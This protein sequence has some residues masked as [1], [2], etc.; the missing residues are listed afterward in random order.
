[1]ALPEL[2]DEQEAEYAARTVRPPEAE[3]PYKSRTLP[4]FGDELF[5]Y[6]EIDEK[7]KVV[8]EIF[9][10]GNP[11]R[12]EPHMV[13]P[14]GLVLDIGANIGAFTLWMRGQFREADI[15]CFEPE[16]ENY[17]LLTL[18]TSN[19]EGIYCIPEGVMG[20]ESRFDLRVDGSGSTIALG[21][22]FKP[23]LKRSTVTV[24]CVSFRDVINRYSR[25]NGHDH[26]DLLKIDAEGAEYSMFAA[27][28]NEF[29][30]IQ[31]LPVDLMNK[32][33]Y[34]TMEFHAP[35]QCPFT[36]EQTWRGFGDLVATLTRTHHVTILGSVERGGY[37]Y[38]QRYG[39]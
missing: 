11:Y 3:P 27:P 38:A 4:N 28:Q 1:M 23:E 8:E 6:R 29:A 17:Q 10:G 18:N 21:V 14:N 2:T 31:A 25:W 19:Q 35:P 36:A 33:N 15:V 26:I 7:T 37:I 16:P 34:I 24:F 22:D 9:D 12:I 13:P 20:I 30:E 5:Y 39:L 32:V